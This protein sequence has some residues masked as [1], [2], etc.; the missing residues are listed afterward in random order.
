LASIGSRF[1]ETAKGDKKSFIFSVS[2]VRRIFGES[3]SSGEADIQ[4]ARSVLSMRQMSLSLCRKKGASLISFLASSA[5]RAIS[6]PVTRGFSSTS[7][8][9]IVREGSLKV[10]RIS[11]KII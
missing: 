1:I 8:K 10:C 4:P 7:D 3:L 9:K 6:L 5:T 11:G 2:S